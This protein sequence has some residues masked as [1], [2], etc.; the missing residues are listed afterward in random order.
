MAEP[1]GRGEGKRPCLLVVSPQCV[2]VFRFPR[3]MVGTMRL[4]F[5][6]AYVRLPA[7]SLR[8]RCN[9][10]LCRGSRSSAAS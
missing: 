7:R 2:N 1:H 3:G 9:S 6:G 4:R 8:H 5:A 10:G